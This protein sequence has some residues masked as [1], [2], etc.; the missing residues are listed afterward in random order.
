LATRRS[1]QPLIAE[2][3][4][5][6][7]ASEMQ[8]PQVPWI[9]YQPHP[10]GGYLA[11]DTRTGEQVYAPDA[12]ALNQFAADHASAPGYGGAGDAVKAVTN[13]LGI[14]GCSPCA[15]RQAAM[16]RMVPN[17]WRR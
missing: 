8:H 17:L 13:A 9:Q 6:K 1:Y 5:G 3:I 12:L 11:L 7:I 10:N 16:N 14:E 4:P 2:S 15:A